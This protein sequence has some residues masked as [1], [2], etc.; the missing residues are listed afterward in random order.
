MPGI[1]RLNKLLSGEAD[2]SLLSDFVMGGC[3][4]ITQSCESVMFLSDK[5]ISF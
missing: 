4:Y 5:I 3:Y 2:V 1:W